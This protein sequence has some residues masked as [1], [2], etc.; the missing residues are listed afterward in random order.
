MKAKISQEQLDLIIES[1]GKWLRGE[2]GGERADLSFKDI[3]GANMSGADMRRANMSGANMIDADMSGANMRRANMSGANMGGAN[4]IDANMRRANMS[5]ADMRRANMSGANMSDADMIDANMIDACVWD[6]NFGGT[7]LNSRWVVV[8]QIGSRKGTTYYDKAND[9]IRCGCF[10]GTL[11]EFK[12]A[13]EREHSDHPVYLA[14]YLAAITYIKAICAIE[15][16]KL[17]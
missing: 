3:S 9:V 8:A 1:H 10:K 16:G 4:M 11:Q 14:E 15:A 2:D 17:P 12:E 5:G 7:K 13:V 6:T